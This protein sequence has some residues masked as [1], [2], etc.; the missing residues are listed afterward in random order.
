MN[1][2]EKFLEV[3]GFDLPLRVSCPNEPYK[4]RSTDKLE[5]CKVCIDRV[6]CHKWGLEEYKEKTNANND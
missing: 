5:K 4:I 3:F 1:N 6:N 2:A